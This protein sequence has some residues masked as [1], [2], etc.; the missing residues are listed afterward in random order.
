MAGLYVWRDLRPLL[1]RF[2]RETGL[3]KNKAVNLALQQFLGSSTQASEELRLR[4]HLTELIH[5]E[6]QLRR[7]SRVM[8]RSGS[9]LPKY[10]DRILRPQ[11]SFVKQGQQPLRALS[12]KEE[13]IFRRILGRREQIVKE[14]VEIQDRLLPK[15]K[16]RLKP[17]RSRRRAKNSQWR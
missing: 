4:V 6:S 8:L 12:K 1:L 3:A 16:F 10:A 17:S 13:G 9:F 7:Q 14:I 15:K 11:D 2:C 5:E